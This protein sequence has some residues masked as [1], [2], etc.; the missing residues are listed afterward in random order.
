MFIANASRKRLLRWPPSKTGAG[1]ISWAHGEADPADIKW[2]ELALIGRWDGGPDGAPSGILHAGIYVVPLSRWLVSFIQIWLEKM[3]Q[4]C[5]DHKHNRGDHKEDRRST[6]P[7]LQWVWRVSWVLPPVEP[8]KKP[9]RLFVYLFIGQP[10]MLISRNEL[11][12]FLLL[13]SVL[14]VERSWQSPVLQEHRVFPFSF[15]RSML[16]PVKNSRYIRQ[17]NYE[18]RKLSHMYKQEAMDQHHSTK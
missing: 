9:C 18:Q 16:Q 8:G 3:S 11:F 14:M 6:A 2:S 15:I 7:T 10:T 5:A 4:F 17:Q 1:C 13:I 12:C